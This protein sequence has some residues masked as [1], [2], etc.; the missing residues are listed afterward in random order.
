M[1]ENN[2]GFQAFLQEEIKKTKGTYVPVRAGFLRRL[3]VKKAACKKLHP[4][5]EDEFCSPKIGPNANILSKYATDFR[6][7]RDDSFYNGT[8]DPLIVEKT[9]P[10]GYMILNGHH[11]WAAAIMS[12]LHR[13]PI[14]IVDLPLE[15]DIKR[16]LQ[17]SKNDRRVALDLD[18]VVFCS[19][20]EPAEKPLP[21]P[22][23]LIY[24]ER[25]RLGIPALFHFFN[26][27]GFDIWVYSSNYRSFTHIQKLFFLYNSRVTG[28]VTGAGKRG[29][30]DAAIQER[31]K[32]NVSEHYSTTI[33]IDSQG[34]LRVD[35]RTGNYEDYAVSGSGADWSAQIMELIGALDK[36]A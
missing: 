3:L 28:I 31:L 14:K 21:F 4:N 24:R 33:H 26:S 30:L 29:H 20:D 18:E 10:D 13:V 6:V 16:M 2:Q 36:N 11:R 1:A 27:R 35:S 23:K 34:M 32:K 12:N 8:Y 17:S 25:I 15:E 9:R 19:G 7:N 5:P 22:L